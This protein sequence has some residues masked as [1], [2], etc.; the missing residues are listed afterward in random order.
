MAG[1][2]RQWRGRTSDGVGNLDPLGSQDSLVLS[3]TGSLSLG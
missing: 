1:A 2:D 3:G